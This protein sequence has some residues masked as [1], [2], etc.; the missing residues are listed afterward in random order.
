MSTVNKAQ[1]GQDHIIAW[2][3]SRLYQTMHCKQREIKF[4]NFAY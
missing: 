1:F 2:Q 3:G 4:H